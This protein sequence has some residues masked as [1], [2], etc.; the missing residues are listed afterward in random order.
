MGSCQSTTNKATVVNNNLKMVENKPEAKLPN[1][2]EEKPT[3]KPVEQKA[4]NFNIKIIKNSETVF[5]KVLPE[6][7][8]FESIISGPE[9]RTIFEASFEY[10]FYKINLTD[11]SANDFAIRSPLSK[12]VSETSPD[13]SE[14]TFEGRY[15]GLDI[16]LNVRQAYQNITYIAVPKYDTEQFEISI[17]KKSSRSITSLTKHVVH[18]DVNANV[19][20]LFNSFS[21]YSNGNDKLFISGGL[22]N[23]NQKSFSE[24]IQIDLNEVKLKQLP[25]L[26]CPR[27]WHSMI[28]VPDNYIFIVGGSNTN[29]VEAYNIETN[30]ITVDSQLIEKRSECS[31]CLINNRYL[32]AFC[33]YSL[34]SNFLNSI[35]M[36]NLRT[37]TR[38]WEIVKIKT[39]ISIEK[40]FYSICYG[41]ED[42]IILIG[43][44]EN[45]SKVHPKSNAS[46]Y[47]FKPS[48]NAI[49]EYR[50]DNSAQPCVISEKFFLPQDSKT[51]IILPTY[52][53]ESSVCLLKFDAELGL[54]NEI[55]F[56]CDEGDGEETNF[57]PEAQTKQVIEN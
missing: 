11:N 43:A 18:D 37:R 47:I 24:F 6:A 55:K 2:A 51:S 17:L 41:M 46:N 30:I 35:E 19:L 34:S 21:G 40:S 23:D 1:A 49:E 31:L 10:K 45:C 12:I 3:S 52:I 57:H 32:Y 42:S 8:T 20:K 16:S 7:T 9:F 26:I 39:E 53:D 36:C 5:E 15:I 44:N 4:R 29:T 54:L 27:W 50:L 13:N 22:S 56:E 28:W 33:G 48:T 14:H 25:N 38:T